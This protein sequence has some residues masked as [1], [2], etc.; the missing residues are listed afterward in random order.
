MFTSDSKSNS[1]KKDKFKIKI[2]VWDNDE[3]IIK[4]FIKDYLTETAT[5]YVVDET[6]YRYVTG[7][8]NE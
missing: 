1:F 2:E 8:K 3:D 4:F 6:N 7:D 5:S